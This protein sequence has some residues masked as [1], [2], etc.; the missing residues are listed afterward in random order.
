M[1]RVTRLLARMLP[2]TILDFLGLIRRNQPHEEDF[3]LFSHF[4]K[5]KGLFI[6]VGAN[7]GQSALSLFNVNHSLNVFSL[8]P[9]TGMKWLLF[10]LQV[11]H[12]FRFRFLLAGAGN[13]EEVITLNI[14]ITRHRDLSTNASFAP[15]E[16]DK[17]YV[18]D[19]LKEYAEKNQGKYSFKTTKAKVICLDSLNLKPLV[20][21]LDV[22]GWE[23]NA[24]KGM[25]ETLK[26]HRPVLMI[27]LNNREAIF[28]WLKARGYRFYRYTRNPEAFD[29][30]E[31]HDKCLNAFCL[32]SD[33]SAELMKHL[34]PLLPPL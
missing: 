27:E 10:L 16:F 14:P 15:D 17:P 12:P 25:E 13:K 19:R 1:K 18:K 8:E 22:E 31:M 30:I 24:L 23:L 3:Y 20:I 6:D 28:P 21:K 5:S 7:C 2:V 26:R 9:N 32:H 33:P 11:R 29:P 4:N 34:S